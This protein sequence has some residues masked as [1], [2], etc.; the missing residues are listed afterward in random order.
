MK[1]K[2]AEIAKLSPFR[3][4]AKWIRAITNH[5]YFTVKTSDPGSTLREEKWSS[6]GNHL[7]N[8]HQHLKN[9]VYTICSHGDL[10]EQITQ[11]GKTYVRDYFTKGTKWLYIYDKW[12]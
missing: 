10:P 9:K 4:L 3:K 1:K 6:L 5:V 2:L 8:V 7:Q 12:L 11:N